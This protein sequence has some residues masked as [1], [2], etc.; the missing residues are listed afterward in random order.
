MSG[1]E[2]D[3]ADMLGSAFRD[4]GFVPTGGGAAARG[5][6]RCRSKARSSRATRSA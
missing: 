4:Q 3:V 5:P 6:A 1:F 2:P